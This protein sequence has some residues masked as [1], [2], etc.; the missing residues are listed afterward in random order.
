MTSHRK[1]REIR[2]M[3]K[4]ISKLT[5]TKNTNTHHPIE[6]LGNVAAT[7]GDIRVEK[8][9]DRLNPKVPFPHKHDFFQFVFITTGSGWHQLDFEKYKAE[10]GSFFI[11]K[12]GQM[13]NWKLN[14]KTSG[15]IIEF[16]HE[17]LP[18]EIAWVSELLAKSRTLPDLIKFSSTQ[19]KEIVQI[20]NSMLK[21][22]SERSTSFQICL[23]NYLSNLLIQ[24]LRSTKAK[25]TQATT[26]DSIVEK[27][28]Q[29]IDQNYKTE[30]AVE[31][32]SQAL[33]VTPK[34][35]TMR[36]TRTVKKSARKLIHERV[37]LEAKRLLAYSNLSVSD[38]GYSLGYDD[39]NYFVRFF[40][41][42]VGQTPAKFKANRSGLK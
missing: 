39:P 34:A 38:V 30:H 33:K 7:T 6:A 19:K 11:V 10:A 28:R 40:H 5:N 20:L 4:R 18:K 29:L 24:L 13:H 26:T 17:S 21:E 32:Y 15:I 2:A 35:L 12:P 25:S 27:F 16:T 9:E 37:L 42:H 14:P 36:V 23:Q 3:P 31:F 8:L 22:F 1:F 41:E